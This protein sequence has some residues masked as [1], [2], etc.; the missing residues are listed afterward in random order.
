MTNFVFEAAVPKYVTLTMQY[1]NLKNGHSLPQL[2]PPIKNSELE[3]WG[4][5][6]FIFKQLVLTFFP[7]KQVAGSGND[8]NGGC[9]FQHLQ[10][11]GF[12]I[13]R[14]I[15]Y[16]KWWMKASQAVSFQDSFSFGSFGYK[17][18]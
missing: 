1:L 8:I 3:D 13:V 6:S 18:G 7:K 4:G 14:C 11:L 15:S 16:S 17:E 2:K 12:F 5:G 10:S 9:S